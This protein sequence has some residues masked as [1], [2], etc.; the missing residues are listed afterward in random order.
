MSRDDRGNSVIFIRLKGRSEIMSNVMGDCL[1]DHIYQFFREDSMTGIASTVDE[2]GY[3]RGAP[4]STFYA[5]DERT[6]LMGVQNAPIPSSTRNGRGKSPFPSSAE[7]MRP[8]PSAAGSKFSGRKW[9]AA[10]T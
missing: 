5:L 9:I 10:N 7:A 4:I 3:P 1:P 2:D 8:L 6:M